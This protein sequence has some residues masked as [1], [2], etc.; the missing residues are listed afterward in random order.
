MELGKDCDEE[1]EDVEEVEEYNDNGPIIGLSITGTCCVC[2]TI[3][4][5]I[6]CA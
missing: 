3:A 5:I 6:N 2:L 1:D 4:G